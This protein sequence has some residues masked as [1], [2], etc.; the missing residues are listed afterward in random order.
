M[1]DPRSSGYEI[2]SMRKT[3]GRGVVD[4]SNGISSLLLFFYDFHQITTIFILEGPH[5][6]TP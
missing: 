4:N 5:G 3:P 6:E 1:K 2:V